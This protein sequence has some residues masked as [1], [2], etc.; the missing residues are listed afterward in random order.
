ME[1]QAH[2]FEAKEARSKELRFEFDAAFE[3]LSQNRTPECSVHDYQLILNWMHSRII[4]E[5]K[6]LPLLNSCSRVNLIR[7][8]FRSKVPGLGCARVFNFG[9]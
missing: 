9:R 2:S 5:C 8:W 1:L 4:R 3:E 6:K 7:S